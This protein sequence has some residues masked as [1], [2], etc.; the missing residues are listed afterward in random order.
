MHVSKK[1]NSFLLEKQSSEAHL[2]AKNITKIKKFVRFLKL[3]DAVGAVG[4]VYWWRVTSSRV[5]KSVN[6]QR[7]EFI[8]YCFAFD[9]IRME[10][11]VLDFGGHFLCY[12]SAR[13]GQWL[14][15]RTF[16]HQHQQAL[17]F[18]LSR[19]LSLSHTHKKTQRERERDRERDKNTETHCTHTHWYS[20]KIS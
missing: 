16:L 11:V 7:R 19:S 14:L 6:S 5:I 20:R 12:F 15:A 18:S 2:K 10:K 3:F 4:E 8:F 17:S 9:F 13:K 1:F